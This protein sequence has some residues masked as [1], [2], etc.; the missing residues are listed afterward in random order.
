[1]QRD[2]VTV[3]DGRPDHV[4]RAAAGGRG[5][6]ITTLS[7][8]RV[9]VSGGAPIP[10]EVID[11]FESRFGVPILEGYG[12][13]EIVVHGDVQHQRRRAQGLQ[14]RQA[15]LGHQPSRS[16]TSESPAAAARSGPR[17]R[18]RA[19]RA[20]HHDRLPQQPRGDREGVRGRLVPH[21]RPRLRRRGRLPVH[22]RPDQGPDH[23]RRVQRLPARGRGGPLRAPGRGRGRGHRRPRRHDGAKRST[24]SWRSRPGSRSPRPS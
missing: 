7:S 22:R 8:L 14:R 18:G 17:G 24:P 12:L 20:Q 2:R 10:A 16:G 5:P 11:S 1:M 21:R 6:A 13:S 4:H 15:D 23:P 3:F 19:A 9:A